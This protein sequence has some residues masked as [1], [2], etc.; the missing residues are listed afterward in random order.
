MIDLTG[1]TV[2]AVFIPTFKIKIAKRISEHISVFSTKLL[3]KC[4]AL[5][6]IEEVQPNTSLICTDS[7]E[8]EWNYRVENLKHDKTRHIAMFVQNSYD[9]GIFPLDAGSCRCG[10]E[11]GSRSAGKEGPET[12]TKSNLRYQ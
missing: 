5:Q 8:T 1:S 6:W 2:G 3:S 12:V 11:Q 4:L 10:R 9:I 7:M